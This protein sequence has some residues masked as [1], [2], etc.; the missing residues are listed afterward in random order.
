MS[1]FVSKWLPYTQFGRVHANS[2]EASSIQKAPVW[3]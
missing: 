2:A 1:S 3:H